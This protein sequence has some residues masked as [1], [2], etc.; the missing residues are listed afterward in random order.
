VNQSLSEEIH[1]IDA[2]MSGQS[3]VL[4]SQYLVANLLK[5]GQLMQLSNIA[6]PG[7]TYWAVFLSTHPNKDRL[8]HLLGWLR[9]QN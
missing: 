2:A 4:A 1:A 3:A 7:S 6:L 5:A 8:E 9:Q